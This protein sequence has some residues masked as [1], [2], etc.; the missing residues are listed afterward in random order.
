MK[1]VERKPV[2][3]NAFK[4]TGEV[5]EELRSL[6]IIEPNPF[7]VNTGCPSCKQSLKN[8]GLFGIGNQFTPICPNQ[9]V[10]VGNGGIQLM[11]VENFENIYRPL[12]TD[13]VDVE[14]KEVEEIKNEEVN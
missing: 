12:Y 7:Q 1:Y 3:I 8:H 6:G 2:S 14:A 11:S 5:T 9:Y 13:I 4:F 10:I